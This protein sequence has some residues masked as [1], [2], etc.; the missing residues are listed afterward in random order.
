MQQYT[1]ERFELTEEEIREAVFEYFVKKFKSNGMSIAFMP[2]HI[3]L[4]EEIPYATLEIRQNK[5]I[6]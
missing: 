6:K 3:N 4:G 5:E 2:E 1:I